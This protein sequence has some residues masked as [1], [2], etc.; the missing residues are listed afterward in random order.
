MDRGTTHLTAV[1]LLLLIL[2]Y[3]HRQLHVLAAQNSV[4]DYLFIFGVRQVRCSYGAV[5]PCPYY[6][7]TPD[8]SDLTRLKFK[9]V[10]AYPLIHY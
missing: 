5:D 6:R 9:Q 3:W 1:Q 4:T 10:G 7:R 8:D 2:T